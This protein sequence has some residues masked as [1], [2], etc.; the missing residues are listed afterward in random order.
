MFSSPPFPQILGPRK[1]AS[2]PPQPY[3]QKPN[4]QY[5]GSYIPI[6]SAPGSY[7]TPPGEGNE[8]PLAPPL[9]SAAYGY[10]LTN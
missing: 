10:R 5:P 7:I 8:G 1:N 2:N 3:V 9:D 4:V 6:M